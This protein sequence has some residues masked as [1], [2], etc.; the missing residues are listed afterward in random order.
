MSRRRFGA[1]AVTWSW[2]VR[3]LLTLPW[4]IPVW[5]V[6]RMFVALRDQLADPAGLVVVV[7]FGFAG[8]CSLFLAPQY[9]RTLWAP[10]PSWDADRRGDAALERRLR[11]SFDKD[12]SP[13]DPPTPSP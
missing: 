13:H 2:P 7:C 8:A 5:L 3:V 6:A 10:N 4:V 1:S 12:S 11:E 9:L